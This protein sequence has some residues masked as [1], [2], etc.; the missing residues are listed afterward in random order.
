MTRFFTLLCFAVLSAALLLSCSNNAP[1]E[2]RLIPKNALAVIT[3]DPYALKDK[4]QN[5]GINIDSVLNGI[6]T[7]DS[8]DIADKKIVTHL[9]THAG[10]NWKEKF[11]FFTQQ[12]KGSENSS[13]STLNILASL[14][15]EADFST[16]LST[17]KNSF[18]TSIQKEKSFS[19]TFLK[20]NGIL[21]WNKSFLMLCFYSQKVKPFYD[22]VNMRFIIPEKT[23][24]KKNMLDEIN[25]RFNQPLSASIASI[26]AF[27][28]MFKQKSEGYI[29]ASSNALNGLNNMSFQLPKLEELLNDNYLAATL[30]FEEGK[31]R[32]SATLFTNPLASSI[33]KNYAGPTVDLSLIN[34]YPS[35]HINAIFMASFN[36]AIASGVLKQLEVESLVNS[37]LSKSGIN[38]ADF[39]AALKGD[40]A[41]VV[42]DL[43][44]RMNEP[45]TK[46]DELS[47]T[48][49]QPIGKLIARL[50]VG[51]EKN[52]HNAMKIAVKEG[53]VIQSGNN[54]KAGELLNAAG[55]FMMANNKEIIIANDSLTY[56]Q[57]LVK[58]KTNTIKP[59]V[60]AYFSGKSTAFYID[61]TETLNG[62]FKD[63]AG[64]FGRT[65][66]TAKNTLKSIY[67]SSENFAGKSILSSIEIRMQ[68][69][70]QN[71]LVTLVSLLT[72]LTV[73][74]RAQA[75][76]ERELEEKQFPAGFPAVIRAN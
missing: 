13:I 72:H 21:A 32:A 73:D 60:K 30:S 44:I 7:N 16:A 10:I 2:T 26:P 29:F 47:L 28:E 64:I 25:Q 3:I 19:Y 31:I 11:H 54:Y 15:N 4:L 50:P 5:G 69:E 9:Q 22:T 35:Q 70:Q 49:K 12:K 74:M 42:S 75:R 24:E 46:I 61:L 36:P 27:G 38:S 8:T 53:W 41:V 6:F 71:S 66:L 1:K 17:N 43:G 18:T 39:F 59:E 56:A 63:S 76:H 37:F 67:G 48:I 20:N 51:N 14:S 57:F 34:N 55:F 23:D 52:F 58:S 68:N 33:L 45:Q 62:F 40:I 65:S